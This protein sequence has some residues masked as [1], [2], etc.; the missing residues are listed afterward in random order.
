MCLSVPRQV[1]GSAVG[2]AAVGTDVHTTIGIPDATAADDAVSDAAAAP[3]AV[4]TADRIL[5]II[6]PHN[7]GRR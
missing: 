5:V 1:A 4:Q 7:P 6:A 2:F 3:A